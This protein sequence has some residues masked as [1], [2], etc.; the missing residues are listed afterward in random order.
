MKLVKFFEFKESDLEPVKSFRI[1]DNLNPKLWDAF[2]F[3]KTKEGHVY[4]FEW[5]VKESPKQEPKSFILNDLIDLLSQCENVLA[6][7]KAKE[8]KQQLIELRKQYPND[9]QFGCEVAK[10]INQ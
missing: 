5:S 2:E 1:K 3:E 10:L 7:N 4:W 9:M 6:Y 8:V